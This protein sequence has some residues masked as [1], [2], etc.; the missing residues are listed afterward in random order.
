MEE[1]RQILAKSKRIFGMR[2]TVPTEQ[3]IAE[4]LNQK[5]VNEPK[6]E[7]EIAE[8]IKKKKKG[9]IKESKAEISKS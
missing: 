8:K 7:G 2:T 5:P 1:M 6:G 4:P 9:G 3:E